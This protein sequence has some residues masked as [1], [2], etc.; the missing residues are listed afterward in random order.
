[1]FSLQKSPQGCQLPSDF[2]TQWSGDANGLDEGRMIPKDSNE[3][4]SNS[5]LTMVNFSGDKR[6]ARAETVGSLVGMWWVTPWFGA[7]TL[8]VSAVNAGRAS[9]RSPKRLGLM[10]QSGCFG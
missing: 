5:V 1:M 9:S 4:V 2:R 6:Q 10:Q 3:G 8:K 7:S